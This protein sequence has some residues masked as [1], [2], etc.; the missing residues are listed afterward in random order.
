[1]SLSRETTPLM[2]PDFRC[3]EIVK[4]YLVVPL[5]RDH[6]SYHLQKWWPNKRGVTIV[7]KHFNE[8]QH[9][10]VVVWNQ[11]LYMHTILWLLSLEDFSLLALGIVSHLLLMFLV[12]IILYWFY[13]LY[14]SHGCTDQIK[15][16]WKRRYRPFY[17]KGKKKNPLRFYL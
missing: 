9:F 15:F 12:L 16:S 10:F 11:D 5:K 1:M 6:P 4:Y 8:I 13:Y 7:L 3:T 14:R 2:R 17:E